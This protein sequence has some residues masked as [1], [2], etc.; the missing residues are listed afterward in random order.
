[1]TTNS[2]KCIYCDNSSSEVPLIGF[3]Y[4][5]DNYWICPMHLPV[6]IHK[7]AQLAD[8]LPGVESMDAPH[9]H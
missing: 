5:E 9:G 6:L 4:Q 8:K 2:A 3:V 7:P 1:M